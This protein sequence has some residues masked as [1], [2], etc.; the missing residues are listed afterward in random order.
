MRG[1]QVLVRAAPLL[2]AAALGGAD[3]VVAQV[4]AGDPSVP[5]RPAADAG[6]GWNEAVLSYGVQLSA[7]PTGPLGLTASYSW[8]TGRGVD[9]DGHAFGAGIRYEVPVSAVSVCPS[10]GVGYSR[11]EARSASLDSSTRAV[12]GSFSVL[13]GATLLDRGR[14]R[15]APFAGLGYGIS[16]AVLDSGGTVTGGLFSLAGGA[17][18]LFADRFYGDGSISL[19]EGGSVAYRIELGIL[20]R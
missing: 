14:T 5:G 17:L 8:M 11:T 16:R 2:L 7:N 6:V 15:V 12:S 10:L 20:L 3:D 13:A 4:C 18:V 9:L 1:S 19:S